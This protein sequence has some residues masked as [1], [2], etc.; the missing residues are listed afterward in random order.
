M[1][2]IGMDDFNFSEM[3]RYILQPGKTPANVHVE[4]MEASH[5]WPDKSRLT[6]VFGWFRPSAL[7]DKDAPKKEVATYVKA[8]QVRID[9]LAGAGELLHAACISRNMASVK[10]FE[11]AGSFQS[12]TNE[13][14]AKPAYQEQLS[15]LTAS[16]QF[17][18]SRRQVYLQSLFSKDET[19]W[20][21]EISALHKK[22]VSEPNE[23]KRMAYK[24]LGGFLGIVCYSYSKQ[25]AEQKDIPHLEQIL[26]IYRLAEP[27]NK[28]MQHY[29]EVLKG[30]KGK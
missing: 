14:T 1:G 12:M 7:P 18:F 2:L 19:W 27:D 26:M 21:N 6:N 29:T 28:D 17:E 11:K 25:L 23:M 16:L 24:R 30:L 13:L 8:Q 22:M 3:V 10:A 20:K 4:L 15:Q 5:A 9:S